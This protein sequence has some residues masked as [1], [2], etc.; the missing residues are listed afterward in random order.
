MY[1]GGD[2][3][4]PNQDRI[5]FFQFWLNN[6]KITILNVAGNRESKNPGIQVATKNFLIA[7]LQES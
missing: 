7:A 2:I 4:P 3:N 1:W 6:A 5:E